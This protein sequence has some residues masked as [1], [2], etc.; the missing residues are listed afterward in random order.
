MSADPV[1]LWPNNNTLYCIA[2]GGNVLAFPIDNHHG[3]MHDQQK[4]EKK[5]KCHSNQSYHV[6]WGRRASEQDAND[7]YARH[8][9]I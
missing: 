3:P 1:H 2:H 8:G 7:I 4:K 6:I 5:K 9:S